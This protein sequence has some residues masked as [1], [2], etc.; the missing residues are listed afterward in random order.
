MRAGVKRLLNNVISSLTAQSLMTLSSTMVLGVVGGLIMYMGAHESAA[1][2]LNA[3]GYVE[4]TMLLAFMIAPIVQLVNIGTQLTEAMAGLDR[5][6]RD[7][8]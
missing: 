6:T 8:E 1:R 3:G 7:S 2:R 4:F 5:T